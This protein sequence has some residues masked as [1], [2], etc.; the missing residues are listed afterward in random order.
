LWMWS[1]C[2]DFDRLADLYQPDA[3]DDLSEADF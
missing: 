2:V 3:G 1:G